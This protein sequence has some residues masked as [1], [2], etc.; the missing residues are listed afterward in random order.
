MEAMWYLHAKVMP[1]APR[2]L[3]PAL[4]EHV[5]GAILKALAKKREDRYETVAAFLE[6]LSLP[7][8]SISPGQK[9]LQLSEVPEQT[10]LLVQEPQVPEPV[11]TAILESLASPLQRETS[12]SQSSLQPP[13]SEE[14]PLA[15]SKPIPSKRCSL[16][17]N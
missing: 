13:M 3:N 11:H 10:L 14:H 5:E 6:A 4:P 12:S 16:G 9:T 17:A 1:L 2:Q 15:P 7:T 8:Q